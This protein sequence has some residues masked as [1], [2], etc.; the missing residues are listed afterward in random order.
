[1]TGRLLLDTHIWIWI[2]LEPARLSAEV[3]G[4]LEGADSLWVSSVSAWEL[5]LL[6]ERGRIDLDR[7]VGAWIDE[8]F[9]RAP[10]RDVELTREIA[11]RSREIGLDHDDPADRF[12]VATAAVHDLIL[13]TADSR[14]LAGTGYGVLASH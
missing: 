11:L 2:I 5:A 10:F 12:I 13:V 3:R 8:A 14:L 6:V 4:R 1:M 7:P 9:R